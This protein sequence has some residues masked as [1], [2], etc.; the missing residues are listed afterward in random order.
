MDRFVVG[1][2][3]NENTDFVL[4]VRKL[5]PEWQKGCLNGIG[6]RIE[7][8]ETSL[9]AMNRECKEET[10]LVLDWKHRGFMKGIN[11]DGQQFECDIFYAYSQNVFGYKQKEDEFLR[12]YR[13]RGIS[14]ERIVANLRF[15]IPYG[16]NKDRPTFM[17]LDH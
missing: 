7:N 16:T 15:L 17:R 4:L 1:F 11:D 6:G 8:D 3:F 10:G 2:A 5:R 13:T 12:L 14:D 9:D